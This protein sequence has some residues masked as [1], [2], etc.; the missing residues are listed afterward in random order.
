MRY[1]KPLL[2]SPEALRRAAEV[3]ALCAS[4]EA[5][6]IREAAGVSLRMLAGAVGVDHKA[7]QRWEVGTSAPA[8]AYVLAYGAALDALRLTGS[9]EAAGV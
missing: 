1:K 4:G 8:T 2:D 3:R 7:V 5:R 9:G 6:R